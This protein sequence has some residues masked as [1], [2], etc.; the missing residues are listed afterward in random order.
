LPEEASSEEARELAELKKYL[1]ERISSLRR[2]MEALSSLVKLVDEALAKSSFKQAYELLK[3]QPPAGPS[4]EENVM[5]IAGRDGKVLGRMYVGPDYVRVE[6]SPDLSFDVSVPPFKAFLV[7]KILEPMKAKDRDKAER[8][9]LDPDRVMDYRVHADGNILKQ[10]VVKN[11][12]DEGRVREL[13]NAIKWTFER[14]LE[15][16]KA[17]G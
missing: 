17:K 10:I 5:L 4:A 9:L 6:P 1:E 15:R 13:R 12:V 3:P 16:M 14:M 11:V 8:G 7:D 2:E